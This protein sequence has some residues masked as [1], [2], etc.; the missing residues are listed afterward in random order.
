M[1]SGLVFA[2]LVMAAAS[3]GALFKPGEWYDRLRKPSWT[4]PRW[5]FPTVWTVLYI[6]IAIS[7]WRVWQ[8][9]GAGLAIVLW[10]VQLVLNAMWSWLFFGLRRMDL[11]LVCVAAL[12]VSVLAYAVAA[13]PVDAIAA[14]LFLP[15][16]A[17]VLAA[18]LLNRSV[19]KLNP[20]A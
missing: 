7:G 19:M 14:M 15:Y 11:A 2:V 10:G 6:L 13:W 3:S 1:I 20:Q 16:A 18:S 8:A 4:P 17:W 12:F 5:V 9:Q